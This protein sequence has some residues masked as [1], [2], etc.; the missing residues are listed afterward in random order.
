MS[1]GDFV[2]YLGADYVLSDPR[3]VERAIGLL[4]SERADAA[5]ISLTYDAGRSY[6]SQVRA[7]EKATFV[8]DDLYEAARLFRKS[9]FDRLGGYDESMVAYEEHDLHN[10]VLAIGGKIVRV[11]PPG[12]V[13]IG[14]PPS[15]SGYVRKYWYYGKTIRTYMKKYPR[16]A[17]LQL[18]PLR[19]SFWK[20]RRAILSQPSLVPG[21]FVY[22]FFRYLAAIMGAAVVSIHRTPSRRG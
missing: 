11:P 17:V 20:S 15:L 19:L 18:F 16:K 12:E 7:F 10:R 6:W 1:V 5:I 2:Y 9:L 4:Q 22:Q 8:G 13:N 3:L 14:D 21:F